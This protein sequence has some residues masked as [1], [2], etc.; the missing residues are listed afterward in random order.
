M[1]PYREIWSSGVIE[2]AALYEVPVIATRVGGL[3]DQADERTVLVDDDR[4]LTEA[5]AAA[6]GASLADG[7]YGPVPATGSEME[8]LIKVRAGTVSRADGTPQPSDHYRHVEH[9][10]LGHA[11][12]VRP[13]VRPMKRLIQRLTAW[14]VEPV[15]RSVNQLIEAAITA[16]SEI[17]EGEPADRS[18]VAE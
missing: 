6:A 18:E 4:E 1:L 10:V 11:D 17:E 7:A 8:A 3:A 14:Q 12:S 9:A 16:T 5:M 13:F 2:R 15:A